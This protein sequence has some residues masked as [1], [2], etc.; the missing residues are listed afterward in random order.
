MDAGSPVGPDGYVSFQG[1]GS[2][3]DDN[4]CAHMSADGS[5]IHSPCDSTYGYVC[6]TPAGNAYFSDACIKKFITFHKG[7]TSG[8]KRSCTKITTTS[9]LTPLI[10]FTLPQLL[11]YNA[12][13]ILHN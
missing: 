10:H 1:D 8:A 13:G 9:T 3:G 11:D 2:T 5:W 7:I 4:I 6:Q 12:Y